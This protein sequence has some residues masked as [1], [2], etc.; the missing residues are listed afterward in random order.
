MQD[1]YIPKLKN[2]DKIWDIDEKMIKTEL[3]LYKYESKRLIIKKCIQGMGNKLHHMQN[4]AFQHPENEKI[5]DEI[6]DTQNK[7]KE[8][9]RA[10]EKLNENLSRGEVGL[11]KLKQDREKEI[12]NGLLKYMDILILKCEK[13]QK[14][15][16]E[17]DKSHEDKENKL[18]EIKKEIK[19]I[20]RL[21][22]IE[23]NSR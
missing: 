4:K 19:D 20:K 5:I 11:L 22:E 16:I 3:K 6:K 23:S 10:L 18:K 21:I 1:D 15:G 7:I 14:E 8:G 12:T 13:L 2:K 9:H 17:F